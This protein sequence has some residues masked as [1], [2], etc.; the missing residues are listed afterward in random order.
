MEKEVS[1]A[2]FEELRKIWEKEYSTFPIKERLR[3]EFNMT[4]KQIYSLERLL[5]YGRGRE[6]EIMEELIG[7][8][9][10]VKPGVV[11][12]DTTQDNSLLQL[13]GL[14]E[15][16]KSGSAALFCLNQFSRLLSVGL[17]VYPSTFPPKQQ[18]YKTCS[19]W[20]DWGI[21]AGHGAI[22]GAL[23]I[24]PERWKILGPWLNEWLPK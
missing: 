6:N 13:S 7:W 17:S 10:A 21:G 24:D 9:I 16:N 23:G 19:I 1:E 2:L 4:Y 5:F 14:L 22:Y 20:I 11:I 12:L 15:R 18:R 3:R 8:L